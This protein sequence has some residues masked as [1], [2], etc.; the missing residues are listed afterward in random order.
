M[1]DPIPPPRVRVTLPGGHRTPARLLGWRQ[2]DDGVWRAEVALEVPAAAVARVAGEDYTAVPR[3]PAPPRYV[4][5]ASAPAGGKPTAELHLATCWTLH[6]TAPHERV[7]PVP[8]AATARG[9]V[10]FADTTAC[11][12]CKPEP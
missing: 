4:L 11:G 5:V 3:Q 6:S 10:G 12:V 8:D 7:T 2:A 1:S 9:M